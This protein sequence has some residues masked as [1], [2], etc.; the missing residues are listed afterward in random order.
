MSDQPQKSESHDPYYIAEMRASVQMPFDEWI[1]DNKTVF[2]SPYDSAG[3]GRYWPHYSVRH[4]LPENRK[5]QFLYLRPDLGTLIF[6]FGTGE[7]QKHLGVP[8]DIV[9]NQTPGCGMPQLS[10][11]AIDHIHRFFTWDLKAVGASG[12]FVLTEA[13]L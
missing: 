1:V 13:Q 11:R 7:I 2:T 9:V 6:Q 3:H 8:D 5:S 12:R 10:D 4:P